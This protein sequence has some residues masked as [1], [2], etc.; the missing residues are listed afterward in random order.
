VSFVVPV[1]NGAL[2][3]HDALCSMRAQGSPGRPIEIIVVEDGSSDESP[4]IL[5]ALSASLD[6]RVIDGPRRGAAAAVNC[7]VRAARYPLVAQV[8]QDVVLSEGWL[9]RVRSPLADPLVGAVQ[10]RYASTRSGSFWS[11]VM[12][13]DLDQRYARLPDTVDHVCTGNSVY[14]KSALHSVNLLRE[15]FGY[16]YD[17]DL[18]YRLSDAGY[19][20][21]FC[22]DAVSRHAWRE[23]LAGYLA[24]QYGFGYGRLDVVA[25]HPRRAAGDAVS[26]ASMMLQPLATLVAAVCLALAVVATFDGPR[27]DLATMLAWAGVVIGAAALAERAVSGIQAW[28]RFGDP[29]GLWFPVAHTMRNLAWVAAIVVWAVRRAARQGLDPSASMKPRA[30]AR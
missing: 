12:A 13:L 29:V 26:P 17:N 15:D 25:A 22:R 8:D 23:G 27:A 16:G 1:R 14:R 28:H 5:R 9:E 30:V 11:R 24:Q 19:R 2:T 10:G 21:A 7:G 3:L 20:L 18:S 4:D 6:L